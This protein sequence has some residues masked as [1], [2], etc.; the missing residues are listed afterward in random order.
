MQ[1]PSLEKALS[2]A[3]HSVNVL[4]LN[5]E[6]ID[7]KLEEFRGVNREVDEATNKIVGKLMQNE[8]DENV[9]ADKDTYT[10]LWALIGGPIPVILFACYA[11]F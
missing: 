8:E 7:K 5:E 4:D 9:D 2:V 1:E 6:Q 11:Q 10:K 3:S